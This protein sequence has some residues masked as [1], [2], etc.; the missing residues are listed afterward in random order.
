MNNDKDRV[1][2]EAAY[3]AHFE[4]HRGRALSPE[5]MA[6]MRDGDGYGQR[7]YL[8]GMW[9]GWKLRD[10]RPVAAPDT[11][12]ADIA[13]A[14]ERA[15]LY[16]DDPRQD[17]KTDVMNAFY[18]GTAH[19]RAL[20]P[21]IAY[22]ADWPVENSIGM[23]RFTFDKSAADRWEDQGAAITPL[24]PYLPSGTVLATGEVTPELFTRSQINAYKRDAEKYRALLAHWWE[25]KVKFGDR[26]DPRE[27]RAVFR[28]S[29]EV[30]H[31]GKAELDKLVTD[32]CTAA[33]QASSHV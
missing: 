17:I 9:Q 1:A 4:E 2:F 13:A 29:T 26:N 30:G 31:S 28:V 32:F 10:A 21:V 23:P 8:N 19:A 11:T 33:Q 24:A 5:D 3:R 6:S 20:S 12:D 16:D 7:P 15:A 14:E 22:K 25:L 18:A 27:I